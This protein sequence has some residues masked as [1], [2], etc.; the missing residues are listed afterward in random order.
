MIVDIEGVD[1]AGKG[2]QTKLLAEG[3][4]R[5]GYKTSVV[6]FPRYQE[7]FFGKEIGFYLNGHFGQLEEIDPK[8]A[9][10]LYAGDRYES[11]Q[12]L[13][14][15]EEENDIV[16][17]DRYVPSNQAH[18]AAKLPRERWDE[19]F[20]WIEAL[21][22]SV[23][24]IKKPD[25]VLFLDLPAATGAQLILQKSPRNYTD[26]VADIH[27]RDTSYQDSVYAAYKA[28]IHQRGWSSVPCLMGAKLRSV[29][30][31]HANIFQI[32][33]EHLEKTRLLPKLR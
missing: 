16:V 22:Y 11:K 9:A 6:Q 12:F 5:I 28:L 20:A 21:E 18:H 24:G 1:G 14:S 8:L 23:F 2:T 7:T 17:L 31:I 29:E 32:V 4:T 30:D 33:R 10:L 3:L 26:K 13:H 27:E 19:F 15:L 25:L